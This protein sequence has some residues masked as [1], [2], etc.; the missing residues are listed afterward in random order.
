MRQPHDLEDHAQRDGAPHALAHHRQQQREVPQHSSHVSGDHVPE[1]PIVRSR[2]LTTQE[3]QRAQRRAAKVRELISNR[4][5][6]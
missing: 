3:L 6:P 4:L 5:N 1:A 2:E